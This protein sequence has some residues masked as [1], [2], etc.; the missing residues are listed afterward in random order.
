MTKLAETLV[1]HLKSCS[2]DVIK[3]L[4]HG[5]KVDLTVKL[6]EEPGEILITLLMNQKEIEDSVKEAVAE[7]FPNKQTCAVYAK[8]DFVKFTIK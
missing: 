8:Q 7:V 3:A 1:R 6:K 2:S 4:E 5:V